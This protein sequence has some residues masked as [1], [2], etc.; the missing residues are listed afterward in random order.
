MNSPEKM[1]SNAEKIFGKIARTIGE[2]V[3]SEIKEES[4][5]ENEYVDRLAKLV[6]G[7]KELIRNIVEKE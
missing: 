3:M 5:F 1:I 7:N 4:A 6:N 2:E